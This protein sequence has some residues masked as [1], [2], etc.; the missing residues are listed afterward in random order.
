MHYVHYH[1]VCI[2]HY[3]IHIVYVLCVLYCVLDVFCILESV[4][5][6]LRSALHY[7]L[8]RTC[9]VTDLYIVYLFYVWGMCHM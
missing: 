5:C 4:F 7:V 6:T 8:R 1:V 2:T 3:V 9:Y